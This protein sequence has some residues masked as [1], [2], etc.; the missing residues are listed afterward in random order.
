MCVVFKCDDP[1]DGD[2]LWPSLQLELICSELQGCVCGGQCN[3]YMCMLICRDA[4]RG[5]V[6]EMIKPSTEC[7]TLVSAPA[8]C[9]D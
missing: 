6:V 4:I 8:A 9:H 3:I 1:A 5:C 7:R 2:K